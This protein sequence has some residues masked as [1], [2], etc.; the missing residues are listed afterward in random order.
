MR[1]ARRIFMNFVSPEPRCLALGASSSI[2]CLVKPLPRGRGG[3]L[4]LLP[5]PSCQIPA[6]DASSCTSNKRGK[7]WGVGV[8]PILKQP[9]LASTSLVPSVQSLRNRSTRDG[10]GVGLGNSCAATDQHHQ[11]QDV[12]PSC[13]ARVKD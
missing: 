10:V 7:T 3:D 8:Q 5:V 13:Y 12:A 4:F 6:P 11:Q 9:C 2:I 1:Y